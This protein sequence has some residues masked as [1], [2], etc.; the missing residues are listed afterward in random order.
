M[1]FRS[2]GRN[3]R[4][5]WCG[6]LA[7]VA[8]MMRAARP[9][10][11]SPPRPPVVAYPQTRLSFPPARSTNWIASVLAHTRRVP[12][13]YCA[14]GG[15]IARKS[16]HQSGPGVECDWL[17]AT[18]CRKDP[19]LQAAVARPAAQN[20]TSWLL[21]GKQSR[22]CSASGSVALGKE[23]AASCSPSRSAAQDAHACFQLSDTT[24]PTRRF[25]GAVARTIF[26]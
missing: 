16:C 23:K 2:R 1:A 8:R 6:P 21:H 13:F 9:P 10:K 20:S 24:I 15:K 11:P 18:L 14:V 22:W 12:Q 26:E 4:R 19:V 25:C 3:R 7:M 17:N 5:D